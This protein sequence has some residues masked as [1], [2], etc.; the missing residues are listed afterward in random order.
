[1][2]S[3]NTTDHDPLK[4]YLDAGLQRLQEKYTDVHDRL[5]RARVELGK[6]SRAA[7]YQAVGIICRDALIEFANAIFSPDFVPDSEDQPQKANA[8]SRIKFTLQ[9]FGQLAGSDAERKSTDAAWKN[10]VALQHDASGDRPKAQRTLLYTTLAI[11]EL[12]ALIDTATQN[13]E[14][15]EH[16]GVYKCPACGSTNLSEFDTSDWSGA[17]PLMLNCDECN[18]LS[19]TMRTNPYNLRIAEILRGGS[20]DEPPP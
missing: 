16:Y 12:A 1:M 11:I 7:E 19:D 20:K 17:G 13:T 5:E 10:A 6:A 14:W 8:K 3:Q 4:S 18:W 15:V 2:D 9:H